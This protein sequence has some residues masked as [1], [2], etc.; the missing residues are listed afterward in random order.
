MSQSKGLGHIIAHSG[1]QALLLGSLHR[2]CGKSCNRCPGCGQGCGLFFSKLLMDWS[3]WE[4][5]SKIFDWAAKGNS[6]TGIPDLKT[7]EALL[8]FQACAPEL[9]LVDLGLPGISG[10]ELIEK[11]REEM[12]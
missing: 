3:D 1:S 5:G 12:P 6:N 9:L 10:V 11:A 7:Q 8:E 2:I 4:N